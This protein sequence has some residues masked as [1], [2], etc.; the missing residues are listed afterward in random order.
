MQRLSLPATNVSGDDARRA[1]ERVRALAARGDAGANAVQLPTR[2]DVRDAR[3]EHACDREPA[4]HAH[5]YGDVARGAKV[6]FRPPS[7]PPRSIHP[8][9]AVARGP[10]SRAP[11][12]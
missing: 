4:L 10:P 7:T 11:R 3:H 2:R 9:A 12:P 5:G 6:Q 8:S 1:Y